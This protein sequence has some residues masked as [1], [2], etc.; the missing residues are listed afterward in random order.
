MNVPRGH[1]P[2]SPTTAWAPLP[3]LA[4]GLLA[5]ALLTACEPAERSPEGGPAGAEA[6]ATRARVSTGEA[7]GEAPAAGANGAG[8]TRAQPTNVEVLRLRARDFSVERTYIG[9]LVPQE[10]VTLRAEIE[11]TVERAAFDKGDTVSAG[12]VIVNISTRQLTIRRNL[13]R[14]NHDLARSTYRRNEELWR[15]ELIPESRLDTSRNQ[16]DVARYNLELAQAELEKS[17]V[18]APIDATVRS[19]DVEEGEYINKG[20]MLA[21]L[22]NL[23]RVRALVNVPERHIRHVDAGDRVRVRVDALPNRGFAGTVKMVGVEADTQNRSFPVE[24]E[25]PNP[26]RALK[27]G[28]LAR[29]TMEAGSYTDEVLI[30]RHAVLER[31]DGR[32]VYVARDGRAEERAVELGV[33]QGDQVHVRQGLAPGDRIIVEGQHQVT[34]EGPIRVL[35]ERPQPDQPPAGA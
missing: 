2:P 19:K 33:S 9:H 11:G 34:R 7:G 20:Q 5:A 10:R 30:P 23:S 25:I 8:P 15:K 3:W 26:E 18:K 28:M 14:S 24:V 21:E 17:R 12:E 35:R 13:A 31:E 1:R 27:P 22:L 29:V 32:V 6:E 16:R 4:A